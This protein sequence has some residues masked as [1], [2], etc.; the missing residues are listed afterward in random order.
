MS[1]C[2][3][4]ES[5]HFS[6]TPSSAPSRVEKQ[7]SV[8]HR[9]V[10]VAST[11]ISVPRKYLSELECLQFPRWTDFIVMTIINTGILSPKLLLEDLDKLIFCQKCTPQFDLL[12]DRWNSFTTEALISLCSSV[13]GLAM[14]VIK[15]VDP[16][17]NI[18]TTWQIPNTFKRRHFLTSSHCNADTLNQNGQDGR[19]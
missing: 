17:W 3:R 15:L 8:T 10:A 19:P 9:L 13:D 6:H 14:L 4:T 11:N 1:I 5:S 2:K 12:I 18:S 7:W 16:S